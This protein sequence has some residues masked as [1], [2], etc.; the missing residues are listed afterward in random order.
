MYRTP[1]G[2]EDVSKF[3]YLLAEL[4]RDTRW[5]EDRLR[6]LI[7]LNLLRVMKKVEKVSIKNDILNTRFAKLDGVITIFFSTPFSII[8]RSQC[9]YS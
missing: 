4:L 5:D 2:L 3:P 9:I 1:A 7:G 6:K 8:Q